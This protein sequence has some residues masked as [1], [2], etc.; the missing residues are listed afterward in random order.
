MNEMT[1]TT[2]HT[3]R[4][5]YAL[6]L[7]CYAGLIWGAVK[8]GFYYLGFTKVIPGFLAEPFYKHSQLAS[9]S[10]HFIGWLY[11]I[12]FSVLAS[13]LYMLLLSKVRG[14][15]LGILYGWV[16]W[17]IIYLFVGPLTGMMKWIGQLDWNSIIVDACLF[18]LWGLFIGYSM[19]V[20]FTDDRLSEPLNN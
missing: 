17:S 20:E 11:F 4:F 10:G 1:Q 9:W 15:W 2:K 19:A 16:W 14:P 7:G 6:S 12:V 5:K 8:I 3:N 13:F 18:T